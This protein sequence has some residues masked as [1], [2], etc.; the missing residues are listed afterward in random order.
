MNMDYK[1][2]RITLENSGLLYALLQTFGEAFNDMETYG[3][4][5]PSAGY[6][7]RLL[8]NSQFIALAALKDEQVVGGLAA[9]ELMKFEQE[10]SEIYIY[11][12]AVSSEHRRQ[13]IAAA[14]VKELNFIAAQRGVYVMF[15]QADTGPEDEAAIAFYSGIGI[16]E[17]VL[18]FDIPV[19]D[20]SK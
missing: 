7:R 3:S 14:L 17:D 8:G 15:V 4:Q 10:R 2:T 12:L 13:G 19:G 20:Y 5:P 18:Q 16:R 11:D 6:M 9:Y 1:I